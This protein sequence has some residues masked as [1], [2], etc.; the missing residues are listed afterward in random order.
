LII[1][2]F[3]CTSGTMLPCGDR[4][5][6]RTEVRYLASAC[7]SWIMQTITR[8]PDEVVFSWAEEKSE[9]TSTRRRIRTTLP[10]AG[11][12]PCFEE[13]I[14][15]FNYLAAFKQDVDIDHSCH[16][17]AHRCSAVQPDCFH[18]V[19][20]ISIFVFSIIVSNI[21]VI[22]LQRLK[23]QNVKCR[24]AV[25]RPISLHWRCTCLR[26]DITQILIV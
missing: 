15:K 8:S 9:V 21:T 24:H 17:P 22:K 14:D 19:N 11:K 25:F 7:S 2:V 3:E 23:F 6:L 5:G 4:N 20:G 18:K 26:V 10:P 1:K 13:R 12:P 16:R